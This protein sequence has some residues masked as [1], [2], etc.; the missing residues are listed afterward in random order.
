MKEEILNKLS[1]YH[2]QQGVAFLSRKDSEDYFRGLVTI[3]EFFYQKGRI[4]ALKDSSLL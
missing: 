2:Q 1:E 3:V 4:D